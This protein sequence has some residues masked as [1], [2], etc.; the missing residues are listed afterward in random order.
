MDAVPRT[1]QPL[2]REWDPI[3]KDE[4]WLGLVFVTGFVFGSSGNVGILIDIYK[5]TS[6]LILVFNVNE[7]CILVGLF[8]PSCQEFIQVDSDFLPIGSGNAV[9]SQGMFNAR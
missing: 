7:P 6:N 5:S 3:K 9:L 1:F 8:D 4:R 2:A